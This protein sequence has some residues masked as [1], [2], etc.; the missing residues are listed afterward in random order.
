MTETGSHAVYLSY[1]GLSDPL[2]Q[3]QIMPVVSGLSA[4][5]YAISVF[6]FEKAGADPVLVESVKKQLGLYRVE[7][8]PLIYHKR[9]PILSTVFDL[10]LLLRRLAALHR[11]KT[12]ALIHARSYIAALA[13]LRM[14][15][16]S[17]IPFIF[18]M[19]GFWADERLEAGIWNKWNP[20]YRW[21]YRYFKA[22]E[23][24]FLEE[25][26]AVVSLTE[27]AAQEMRSWNLRMNKLAV[28]PTC[29]DLELFNPGKINARQVNALKHE[30]NIAGD[31][32]VLL[33]LGS[34]GTWYQTE[35]ML[36][37]YR[38][39]R[40][41]KQNAKFLVL[42]PRPVEELVRGSNEGIICRSVPHR[43]VPLYIGL[44]SAAVAFVRP[45]FSKKASS[46]TKV[47]ELLSMG[48]PLIVN[49]G[50]GDMDN[51]HFSQMILVKDHST[52]EYDQ[53]INKLLEL[54]REHS[55]DHAAMEPLSTEST[56][57]KYDDLYHAI[58]GTDQH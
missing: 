54:P 56:V 4:R 30:M 42:C 31:D 55:A 50:W 10:L 9:P 21:V 40:E 23:K 24:T 48:V 17:S 39:I 18:D 51:M 5:G 29:V 34:W 32:Y 36:A 35:E 45:S 53:A 8:Y 26:A 43:E 15:K 57:K 28:I 19:R 58:L 2:G 20:L 46:A 12:I 13:A 6:S 44:A 38:R 33:Y 22:K 49:G 3:S 41:A 27:N 11:R 25:A 37:F 47:A 14:K 1:D 7:W 16:R 52:E